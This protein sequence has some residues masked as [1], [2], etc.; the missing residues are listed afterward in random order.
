MATARCHLIQSDSESIIQLMKRIRTVLVCALLLA[1]A[2]LLAATDPAG[3]WEGILNTPNGDLT[4]R[5]NLHR[6]GDKWAAEMDLVEQGV[7]ELP[8]S[9]IKVDGAAI[10]FP[11]PGPGEPHYEGKLSDDGKAITGNLLQ[12]GGSIPLNLK[13]KSAARAVSKS[14]ANVGEV[15]V[16]E[17]VWEGTLDANGTQLRLRFNFTK[18]GDGSI[19]GTLDSVDQ[20]VNGLPINTISRTGDAVKMD[21]KAIGGTYEGT[22]DKDASTIKGTWSQGGGSLPLTMQRKKA[23]KKS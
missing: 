6:D 11:I 23:E 3:L 18:N 8:L 17:G 20:G 13:W 7:S 4:F 21:V 9:N 12:G 1:P 19:T 14:A 10:S 5:F 22:L 16:L 15:Q 2:A